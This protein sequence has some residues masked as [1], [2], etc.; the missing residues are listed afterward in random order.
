[1][2][3]M[4][5]PFWITHQ[6]SVEINPKEKL[7]KKHGQEQRLGTKKVSKIVLKVL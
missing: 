6:P 2:Q 4:H 5:F 1:M 7:K 3:L